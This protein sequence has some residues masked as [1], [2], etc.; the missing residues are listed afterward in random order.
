M[1]K[2]KW[3]K[4]DNNFDVAE[5]CL[6]IIFDNIQHKVNEN[7]FDN[8][9][10]TLFS[11]GY[12]YFVG[13]QFYPKMEKFLVKVLNENFDFDIYRTFAKD[14]ESAIKNANTSFPSMDSE[15]EIEVIPY[16][17]QS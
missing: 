12:A 6:Q 7:D 8:Q 15:G 16:P 17:F 1:K 13:Y 9:Y 11:D 14:L 2:Q 4:W 10:P 5:D 3:S